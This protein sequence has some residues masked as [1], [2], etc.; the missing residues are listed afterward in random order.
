MLVIPIPTA[1]TAQQVRFLFPIYCTEHDKFLEAEISLP[2]MFTV[3]NRTLS[4]LTKTS[5]KMSKVHAIVACIEF[6]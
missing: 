1:F 6:V 5:I 2:A 3:H 4:A